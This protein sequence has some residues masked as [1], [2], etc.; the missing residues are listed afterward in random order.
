M[1]HDFYRPAGFHFLKGGVDASGKLVAWRNHFVTFGEGERFAP[2]AQISPPTEFPARFVSNFRNHALLSW[3]W[4]V[5]H[6]R[7]SALLEATAS[8]S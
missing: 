7:D 3:R 8:L 2:S 4:G 6:R 1:H 5:P